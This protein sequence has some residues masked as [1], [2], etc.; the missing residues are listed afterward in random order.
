V[1]QARDPTSF[2]GITIHLSPFHQGFGA[3]IFQPLT[4]EL[5]SV[6]VL[7]NEECML[8]AVPASTHQKQ[9]QGRDF[10]LILF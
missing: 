9:F 5:W 1:N 6:W 8:F 4:P 7:K 3:Y 2:G 10:I